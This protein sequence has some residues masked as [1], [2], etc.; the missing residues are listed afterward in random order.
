MKNVDEQGVLC[1][2]KTC[3]KIKGKK[4]SCEFGRSAFLVAFSRLRK[5]GFGNE[6]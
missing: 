5:K 3:G 1:L 6:I 2:Q 4:L